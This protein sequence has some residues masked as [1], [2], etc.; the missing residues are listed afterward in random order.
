MHRLVRLV[1]PLLAPTAA[2][3]GSIALLASPARA[4]Q[5]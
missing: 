4:Q 3:L 1:A 2:V 5:V